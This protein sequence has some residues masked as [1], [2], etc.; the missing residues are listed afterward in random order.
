MTGKALVITGAA[1]GIGA[2]VA[3]L[4]GAA[5]W[6][7]CVNY[8][9]REAEAN[10]VVARITAA[11]GEAFAHGCDT[12]DPA[13][14]EAMFDAAHKRFGRLD[15]LVNNAGMYGEQ[16]AVADLT[17]EEIRRLLEV[18]VLGY[19]ICAGQAIRRMATRQGGAGGRIVNVSSIAGKNGASPGRVL[20]G[21]SKGAI[22]TFTK[23][24]AKEVA[25]DGITV[26]AFA[27]G[28]TDTGFNPPGRVAALADSVPLG[29]A[30]TP[31][32]MAR[33]VLWLLSDDAAYCT[34]SCLT[35]SGGR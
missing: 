33:G 15:A 29:R 19:V 5:G 35:M 1:S 2:E 26:N 28:L 31:T 8:R 25:P 20:Y 16:R 4:A 24:L 11:G 34:G 10:A 14:V 21:L 7:V 22:D 18:N 6:R 9:S 3:R 27:P 30:G 23:G 17:A 12:A 13:G 32:E